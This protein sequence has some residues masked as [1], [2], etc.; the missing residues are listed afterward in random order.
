M[1]EI[2]KD[3]IGYEG[4]YQI[5]NYGNVRSL[6]RIDCNNRF[7]KGKE[8]KKILTEDG[9]YKVSLSKNGKD[10]RY[11]IH[12]LVAIHF[13]DKVEGCDCVN[14]KDENKINNMVDNLEW[15]T[16][17]YNNN[18]GTRNQRIVDAQSIKTAMIDIQT[19]K[20]VKIFKSAQLASEYIKGDA[21]SI[22]KARNN[23]RRTAY[24]YRWEVVQ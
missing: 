15:C 23:K 7:R 17:Y 1:E 24:G 4:Y 3:I 18:Y 22:C 10:K 21:S 8:C 13:L 11:F 9:Y 14:H 20:I 16:R 6:D 19:G 5:S 12:R 2:W